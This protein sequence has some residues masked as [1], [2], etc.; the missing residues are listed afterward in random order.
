MILYK[1]KK[2]RNSVWVALLF[3]LSVGYIPIKIQFFKNFLWE[4]S[5]ENHHFGASFFKKKKYVTAKRFE[6]VN[7]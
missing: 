2:E 1:A 3:V 7:I 4:S 5:Y 6:E